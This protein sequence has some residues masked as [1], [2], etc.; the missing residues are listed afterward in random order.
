MI[1]FIKVTG[2]SLSPA[3]KEGD[4]VMLI[5]VPFLSFKRGDTIVFRH[6]Q[7]GT[8]IKNIDSIDSD[9][10][11]VVGTHPLS[12]DSRQFGPIQRGDVVGKVIWH[13]KKP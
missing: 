5:T 10:I 8:M 7:Y 1:K 12:I 3:Y 2:D 11:F 6:T 4:Y 9:K 13:I